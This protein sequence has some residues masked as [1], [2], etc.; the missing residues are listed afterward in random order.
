MKKIPTLFEREF[1]NHRVIGVTDKYDPQFQWVFDGEGVA[2][3]KW[4]G[5]CCAIIKGEFYKRYDAKNGKSIPEGAIKCQKEADPVTG[6]LPCWVKCKRDNPDDK[7]FWSAYDYSVFDDT[8]SNDAKPTQMY[9]SGM[10]ATFEAIGPHFQGN[11]YHLEHD[12]LVLHGD[13]PISFN[14]QE[15]TFEIIK[16]LLEENNIEG[17]VFWKDNEPKVKIKSSDFGIN[18]KKDTSKSKEYLE[19]V[20]S[21]GNSYGYA[22]SDIDVVGYHKI[23]F[24][25]D[26]IPY[27]SLLLEDAK[28]IYEMLESNIPD[29]KTDVQHYGDKA[30][31]F[32]RLYDYIDA[33][34]NHEPLKYWTTKET[35]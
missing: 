13:D 15:I 35:E 29:G 21:S 6:H 34:E 24:K 19:G 16:R 10:T 8:I 33:V 20:A 23:T 9:A 30:I 32:E 12:M 28:N 18:W 11:P 4:D 14:G 25:G 26:E 1:A 3:V 2:T 31:S 17:I 5:S 27:I 7:W 22:A